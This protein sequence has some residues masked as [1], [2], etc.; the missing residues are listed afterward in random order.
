MRELNL[1]PSGYVDHFA[2]E[3]LPPAELW[4]DLIFNGLDYPKRL[5]GT[6]ELLK[7]R[8][9]D[10]AIKAASGAWS[11]AQLAE[12][13]DR[14]ASVLV[15][16]LGMRPGN[17]VLLRGPNNPM[18]AASILAVWKAGGVAVNTM[19]LLRARE[20]GYILDKAQ[21]QFALCDARFLAD[22]N[23]AKEQ[24]RT[25][26]KIVAFN[27][28]A[29][30][31]LES[32][33]VAKRPGFKACDTAADDVCL[34]A[35]TS[36]TTGLPKGTMHFHRDLLAICD[37][38]PTHV[39]R[40]EPGDTFIG[41]PPF[42]FTFGLGVQLLFPLRAGAST[43]LVEQPSPP[44]LIT[45][46]GQFGATILSTAPT[47]YRAM[48]DQVKPGQLASLKKCVSA[49]EHLPLATFE[50]W[51]KATG[52]S[53]IDG[54]GSTE[55]L[56]IFIA[57][58]GDDIRPGSTG[59]AVP[60]YEARVVDE[61]G[62]DV[63]AGEIG[64]LA[65]RGPTGC[66][67]LADP[68]RQQGYVYG[69]WNYTGDAYRRDA[70]GYFW[71]CARTDDMIVSAGYN[72]SGPEVENVLLDHPK[73]KECGVVGAPDG[74][75][76]MIVKA[77]VVLRDPKDAGEATVKE[78]QDYVKREIAPYKYPRAVAFVET[79]PRTETGKLQRFKLRQMAQEGGTT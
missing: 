6:V 46:I 62:K 12:T 58:S 79:L 9:A 68:E 4:P 28:D 63:P 30:D 2:R 75:R 55:M 74:Q 25:L 45:A 3:N 53:I 67:Y 19:P 35:F 24:S 32:L 17:R 34:I 61:N 59:R 10:P 40:P 7:G 56:H 70:D 22:L 76:G 18:M 69:G 11:Y 8:P 66:R 49:G 64:R 50:A 47:A 26:R 43:A 48:L 15:E 51:R 23:A 1:E 27:S 65:V 29:I 36:G 78:L 14:I 42:A 16:D 77:Y 41:S 31:S 57:A 52:I 72:I 54:I 60:G 13:V 39:I 21:V 71:Y 20:L 38:T 5:N 73:V 33:L 44:N 37:T